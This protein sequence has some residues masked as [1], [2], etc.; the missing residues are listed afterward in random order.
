MFYASVFTRQSDV[1]LVMSSPNV[2][3]A[4][5]R[6]R[7]HVVTI[8][9][10][11]SDARKAGHVSLVTRQSQ[12][13]EKGGYVFHYVYTAVIRHRKLFGDVFILWMIR[14]SPIRF[15]TKNAETPVDRNAER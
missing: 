9:T 14:N 8:F 5:R 10:Q 1:R 2:H 4:V 13:T 3:A 6:Q 12:V 15:S 11:Q 7:G